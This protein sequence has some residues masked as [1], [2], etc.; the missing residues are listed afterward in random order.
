ME[1]TSFNINL[2]LNFNQL[3]E[4]IKQL[5]YNEKLKLREVL[6]KE[7]RQK[8]EN[9]NTLTHYASERTLAKDWLLHEEDEV[10]KNL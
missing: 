4:I 1:T 9:D 8:P 3:V 5:P 7:T 10:W 2:P 6:K